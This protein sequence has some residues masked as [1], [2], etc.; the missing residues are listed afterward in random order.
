MEQHSEKLCTSRLF[1]FL[2]V[3]TLY[4]SSPE[5]FRAVYKLYMSRLFAFL[6]VYSLY[7]SDFLC[8]CLVYNFL[9]KKNRSEKERR[10]YAYE[11]KIRF[12]AL[13]RILFRS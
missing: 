3:Y 8:F 11:R 6:V 2:V 10:F 7:M 12:C 1:A 4:M 5:R 13:W 9:R